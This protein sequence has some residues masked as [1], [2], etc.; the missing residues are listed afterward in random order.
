MNSKVDE[1]LNSG[2]GRCPLGGTSECKVHDWNN[3]LKLLRAI[4]LQSNLEE[5]LKWGVPCYTFKERNILILSA[6]KDHVVL[7]FFK[8]V[9]LSDKQ[10]LLVSPGANSQAVRQFRFYNVEEI[11]NVKDAIT[12]YIKEAIEIERSG[13]KVI[14]KKSPEPLPHELEV[15]L[16]KDP[17]LKSA[18]NALS[19]GKQRGYILFISQPK[20]TKTRLSRIEKCSPMI[21]SGIGLH[22]KYKS[23]KK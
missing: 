18:F 6:L 10:R 11:E 22:D 15:T 23:K 7:G 16:E 1:Y 3:E 5:E 19:P 12:G 17:I 4:I 2:C 9:L 20:Q 21:L 14:F 8:G 13:R